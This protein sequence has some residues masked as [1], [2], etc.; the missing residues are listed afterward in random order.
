[1]HYV[2]MIVNLVN[3]KTYVGITTNPSL[4]WWKH[5]NGLGSRL[6]KAAIAK[7]GSENLRF[8]VIYKSADRACVEWMERQAIGELKTEAPHGYNRN[9]G[10]GGSPVGVKQ[11]AA[12][13]AK[14]AA[15]NRGK[16][17]THDFG[18][19]MSA[20]NSGRQRTAEVRQRMSQS[21]K[22][23]PGYQRQRETT[24]RI[25]SRPVMV[26]GSTYASLKSASEQTG[27]SY[28]SLKKRFRRYDEA[29]SFPTGWSYLLPRMS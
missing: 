7:Y 13:V 28:S 2:Y 21:R 9:P 11:S 14:R 25:K 22:G 8:A 24:S 26:D 6:V 19:R 3:W 29:N 15:A 17:R 20:I 10:G 23:H 4:R 1:M 12:I 16:K 27:L 5:R 18:Q